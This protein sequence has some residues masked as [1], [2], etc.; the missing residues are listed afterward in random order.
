MVAISF[1]PRAGWDPTHLFAAALKA[2]GGLLISL[3]TLGVGT[4]VELPPGARRVS[5]LIELLSSSRLTL[6]TDLSIACQWA[7]TGLPDNDVGDAARDICGYAREIT[8]GVALI[9]CHSRGGGLVWP[10]WPMEVMRPPCS[11]FRFHGWISPIPDG[12]K[13]KGGL[14]YTDHTLD[15]RPD[16]VRDLAPLRWHG[17]CP[18]EVV[19]TI[20]TAHQILGVG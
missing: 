14:V 1:I 16:R 9:P 5:R 19:L 20:E 12:I 10:E 8:A 4:E 6:I 7:V 13:G 17:H 11:L 3:A 2:E 15:P 18:G